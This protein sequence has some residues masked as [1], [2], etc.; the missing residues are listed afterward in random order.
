MSTSQDSEFPVVIAFRACSSGFSYSLLYYQRS[1]RLARGRKQIGA[2]T[3]QQC[4][5]EAD[6]RVAE[7]PV[8]DR[9]VFATTTAI[10]ERLED[11]EEPFTGGAGLPA[12]LF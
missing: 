3:M 2:R 7:T 6:H 5:P 11:V 4:H 9:E 1:M 8:G 12:R 10:G